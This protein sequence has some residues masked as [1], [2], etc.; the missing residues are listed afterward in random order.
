MSE[1]IH[2][3]PRS[4]A[5]LKVLPSASPWQTFL[6]PV[7]GF[8]VPKPESEAACGV[9]ARLSAAAAKRWKLSPE[10]FMQLEQLRGKECRYIF[11]DHGKK[12]LPEVGLGVWPDREPPGI[13]TKEELESSAPGGKLRPLMFQVFRITSGGDARR[14]ARD[15]LFSFGPVLEILTA[16]N[17]DAFLASAKAVYLRFI[18]DRSYR[19]Y[20]YYVPL[21]EGKTMEKASPQE[22]KE[23]CTGVSV[24]I[25]QSFEDRGILI[26]APVSL[27]ELFEE[28]GGKCNSQRT[29]WFFP[30]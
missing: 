23:W 5:I 2:S 20:P 13:W 16:E 1:N 7:S 26:T 17:S 11:A 4:Q 24:Y 22:L 14:E 18:K 19:C 9:V 30:D 27:T 8:P 29:E 10:V 3:D 25:R 6:L 21:L 15:T 12:W 28:V